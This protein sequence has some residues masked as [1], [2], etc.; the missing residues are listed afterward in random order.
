MFWVERTFH[1]F[2]CFYVHDLF[3]VRLCTEDCWLCRGDLRF[4]CRFLRGSLVHFR[5]ANTRSGGLCLRSCGSGP[6]F[7]WHLLCHF[8]CLAFRGKLRFLFVNNNLRFFPWKSDF[9][10][11]PYRYRQFCHGFG[12]RQS[13]HNYVSRR[14]F[15]LG[16]SRLSHHFCR[17]W[18]RRGF[19]LIDRVER[20]GG[21]L[22]HESQRLGHLRFFYKT[23][24]LPGLSK[25]RRERRVFLRFSWFF[26][27][28]FNQ[29]LR[30]WRY[31][32]RRCALLLLQNWGYRS[33]YSVTS[34]LLG[35][36][37][38]E[39]LHFRAALLWRKFA[40]T[41]LFL[42][43]LPDDFRWLQLCLSNFP[44]RSY[45]LRLLQLNDNI[46]L[47]I[48]I[49]SRLGRYEL[50]RLDSA[51]RRAIGSTSH[52]SDERCENITA[53]P[54]GVDDWFLWVDTGRS[55]ILWGWYFWV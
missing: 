11:H 54:R 52:R 8:R 6:T 29:G 40:G 45:R 39:S 1:N 15:G 51:P 7:K 2:C 21:H 22:L 35:W 23:V 47:M 20:L 17:R 55:T 25:D 33:S 50:R 32:P 53:F 36:F 46:A 19:F 44:L 42:L 34:K 43:S 48:E 9:L 49:N 27:K 28:W 30:W 38:L 13:L 26:E 37:D 3:F 18:L 24:R 14:F 4:R 10:S 31:R 12:L 5:R 16:D 41:R